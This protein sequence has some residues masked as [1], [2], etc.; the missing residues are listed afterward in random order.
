MAVSRI[1]S[2]KNV[3]ENISMRGNDGFYKILHNLPVPLARV[4]GYPNDK[5]NVPY[6][7]RSL[8]SL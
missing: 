2:Q 7:V 8:D 3:A 5:G 1:Y 6:N 4:L